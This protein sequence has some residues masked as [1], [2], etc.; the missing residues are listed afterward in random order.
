[1]RFRFARAAE[2]DLEE[3]G[4]WIA[5]YDPD[6]A[7]RITAELEAKARQIMEMPYA[8]PS[9]GASGRG[10]LRK[11]SHHPYIIYYRVGRT[12]LAIVRIL[13]HS[14]NQAAL[15]RKT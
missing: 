10:S 7:A 2:R 5:L 9:V 1:M 13:R 14:R 11:R 8:F 12:T 15:L 3:I 4:D 6:A